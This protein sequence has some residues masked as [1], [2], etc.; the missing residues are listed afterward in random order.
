LRLRA[1]FKEHCVA[2]YFALA[3]TISWVGVLLVVRQLGIPATPAEAD[4]FGGDA[5]MPISSGRSALASCSSGSSTAGP[6]S[7]TCGHASDAGA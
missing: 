3:I 7:V 5:Y 1:V 6:G 2:G 4:E